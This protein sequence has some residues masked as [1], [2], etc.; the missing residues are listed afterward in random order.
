MAENAD[1]ITQRLAESVTVTAIARLMQMVGV[2]VAIAIML[3]AG[4]EL[5]DMGKVTAE[6]NTLIKAQ[7]RQIDG[8]E[9][10]LNRLEQRYFTAPVGNGN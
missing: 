10:R 5:I 7:Q 6:T 4:R 2:P 3:W 8:H 9:I 1:G